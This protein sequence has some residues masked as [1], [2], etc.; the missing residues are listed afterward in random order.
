MPEFG[1]KLWK[2]GEIADRATMGRVSLFAHSLHYGAAAFEGIRTYRRSRGETV[3]FRL[4]EHVE[5]LFDSAR[6]V[7]LAPRVA[8]EAVE[9]G[10]L[11]VARENGF[12][13]AYLRPL[14]MRGE[15]SMALVAKE[16]PVETYI[17]G[18]PW[19]VSSH[20]ERA[21]RGIRCKVS[22]F[23]R[24][25]HGTA[26]ARGKITGH[27]VTSILAADEARL[28]GYDEALLLDG[29]GHVVESASA[30]LFAVK[31]ERL[32]TPPL[33][34]SVL[35]GLTRDALL[36]LARE[37][38]FSVVEEPAAR[39][40]LYVADEVFLAGTASEITPVVEIDDYAINGGTVGPVTR[41][42]QQRFFDVVRGTDDS[43]PEWLTRV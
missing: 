41:A 21:A 33:W 20:A 2:D 34:S 3:V 36:V 42:L 18:W 23:S 30:N 1:K 39:D 40:W 28:G 38:G 11:A 8:V 29:H 37:E 32:F 14:V 25:P 31:G 27:Y 19:D 6:L 15:G 17:V 9:A 24:A 43:H 4:R 10:C 35:P 22:S 16:S 26:F 13:D 12:T 7:R 5:R